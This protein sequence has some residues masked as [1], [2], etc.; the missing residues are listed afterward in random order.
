M[1]M[2]R[3]LLPLS[4]LLAAALAPGCSSGGSGDVGVIAS[5]A[6]ESCM[7]CHNGSAFDDYAGPGL[8]NPHPFGG[9]AIEHPVICAVDRGMVRGML[10]A[11]YGET[12][13]ATEQSLAKGDGQ[14][15]VTVDHS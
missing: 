3:L 8:E 13:T 1:P 10:A 11:L 7:S 2:R 4:V 6:A 14:C 9:A 5:P 12:G 15:A